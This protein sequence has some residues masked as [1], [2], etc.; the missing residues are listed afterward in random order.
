[1]F[2][3]TPPLRICMIVLL[4]VADADMCQAKTRQKDK[5]PTGDV[6]TPP[7]EMTADFPT[8]V[9][10]S[11]QPLKPFDATGADGSEPNIDVIRRLPS[12][13]NPQRKTLDKMR[14]DFRVQ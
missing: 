14:T 8:F 5:G 9:D 2:W 7:A 3:N 1:M 10:G 4:L 11:G 13:T 6:F 12:L